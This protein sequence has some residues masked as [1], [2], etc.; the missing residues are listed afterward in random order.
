MAL[1]TDA[2]LSFGSLAITILVAIGVRIGFRRG[3][4]YGDM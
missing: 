1:L 2:L 3:R 4:G